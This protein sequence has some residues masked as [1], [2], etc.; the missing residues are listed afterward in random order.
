MSDKKLKEFHHRL[1]HQSDQLCTGSKVIRELHKIT[2]TPNE[3]VK[4]RLAKQALFRI[5]IPPPKEIKQPYYEVTKSMSSISLICFMY[6]IMSLK[7]TH[8]SKY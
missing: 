1:D 2:S 8:T 4:S 5:H 6:L 7:G 3:D